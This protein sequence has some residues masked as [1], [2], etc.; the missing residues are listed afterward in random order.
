[1]AKKS[2]RGFCQTIDLEGSTIAHEPQ[3]LSENLVVFPTAGRGPR[4][5]FMLTRSRGALVGQIA[6]YLRQ[7]LSSPPVAVE[8]LAPE[9]VAHV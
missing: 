6:E 4:Y 9:P 2:G 1:V 5:S 8:T 7:R 3:F